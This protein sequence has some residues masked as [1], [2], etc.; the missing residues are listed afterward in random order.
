LIATMPLAPDN[1]HDWNGFAIPERV[2]NY[3]VEPDAYRVK[4]GMIIFDSR[5]IAD[6][7]FAYLPDGPYPELENGSF[8]APDYLPLGDGWYSWSASW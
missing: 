2:G 4:G 6:A 5:G 7:G 3:D 1:T 8:E